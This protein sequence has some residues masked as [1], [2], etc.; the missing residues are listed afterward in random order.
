VEVL[1]GYGM[2]RFVALDALST[3]PNGI[4]VALGSAARDHHRFVRY[5]ADCVDYGYGISDLDATKKLSA[6][7]AA[8]LASG[9]RALRGAIAQL[10]AQRPDARAALGFREATEILLK[11]LL[12]QEKGYGDGELKKRFRHSIADIA[13]ECIELTNEQ[14]FATVAQSS[15]VFP[16]V[17]E[18]YEG[19]DRSLNEVSKAVAVAQV[20]ATA[21]VHRYTDRDLREQIEGQLRASKPSA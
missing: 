4:R 7:A 21:V 17:V 12:V 1:H 16:E 5:W 13:E 15:S 11:A 19:V 8:F 20:A 14:D 2:V 6:R 9:D 3:M 10:L 18:R